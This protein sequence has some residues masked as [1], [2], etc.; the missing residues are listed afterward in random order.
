VD[1]PTVWRESR[2]RSSCSDAVAWD[3]ARDAKSQYSTQ[4]RSDTLAAHH[5]ILS[6]V[7]SRCLGDLTA[8]SSKIASQA[9]NKSE[10]FHLAHIAIA[11]GVDRQ[12]A[13]T[14]A[15]IGLGSVNDVVD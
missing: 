12:S 8:R 6:F 2:S 15:P 13:A 1:A 5:N 11:G 10:P 4:R 9:G 14:H 7:L 3:S